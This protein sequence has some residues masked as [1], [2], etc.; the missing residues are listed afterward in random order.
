MPR[1]RRAR[2]KKKK[3]RL[4]RT[5]RKIAVSK[6]YKSAKKSRKAIALGKSCSSDDACV[7]GRCLGNKCVAATTGGVF[8][9]LIKIRLELLPHRFHK[10]GGIDTRMLE[11]NIIS[12]L[13]NFNPKTY[14]RI[15]PTKVTKYDSITLRYNIHIN[16]SPE[17]DIYNIEFNEDI[18]D[19]NDMMDALYYLKNVLMRDIVF[20]DVEMPPLTPSPPPTPTPPFEKVAFA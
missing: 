5:Y 4:T 7:S 18:I 13:Q 11:R 3:S 20:P 2:D 16:P 12:I 8:I 1:T 14:Q 19:K 10:T 9:D 15:D 17:Q 6:I